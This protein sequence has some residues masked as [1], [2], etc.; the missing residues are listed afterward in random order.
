MKFIDRYTE[1]KKKTQFQANCVSE[2]SEKYF[3]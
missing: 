1:I 3:H 2:I